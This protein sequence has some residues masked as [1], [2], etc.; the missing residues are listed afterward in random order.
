MKNLALDPDGDVRIDLCGTRAF[1]P[2]A[3]PGV[4]QSGFPVRT[5][6][7]WPVHAEE[8]RPYNDEMMNAD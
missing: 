5:E 2:S 7:E 4:S 8:F 1:R 3:L 6:L